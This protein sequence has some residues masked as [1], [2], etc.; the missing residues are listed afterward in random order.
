MINMNFNLKS[1]LA[2]SEKIGKVFK[3]SFLI[4]DKIARTRRQIYANL[5]YLRP[6]GTKFAKSVKCPAEK[7]QSQYCEIGKK[8]S[9]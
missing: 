8:R 1:N 5:D 2:K 9:T 7:L 6:R 4:T 3:C